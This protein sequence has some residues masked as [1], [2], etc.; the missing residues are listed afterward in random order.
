MAGSRGTDTGVVVGGVSGD[1]WS[2]R[3]VW[4]WRKYLGP[5]KFWYIT[6][7]SFFFHFIQFDQL[8]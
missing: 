1:A 6:K 8:R 4:M 5:F 3:E 2:D 7:F